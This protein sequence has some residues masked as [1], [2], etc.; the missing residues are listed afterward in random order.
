MVERTGGCS[1]GL[2]ATVYDGASRIWVQGDKLQHHA[3]WGKRM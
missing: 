1:L 3:E 2:C